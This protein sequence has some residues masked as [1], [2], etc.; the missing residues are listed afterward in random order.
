MW[1]KEKV[2]AHKEKNAERERERIGLY[3]E[4]PLG[5]GKPSPY[6]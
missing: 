3:K 6:W 1:M 2:Y 5:K 4:G